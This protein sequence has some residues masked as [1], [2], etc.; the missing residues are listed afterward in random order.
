MTT[1]TYETID[2]PGSIYT[3]AEGINSKGQIVGFYQ[4]SNRIEHGF[5]YDHGVYTT[6]DPP[7]SGE[8]V[9]NGI[10]SKGQIFGFYEIGGS[11]PIVGFLY[12]QG[13]YKTI[14]P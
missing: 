7:G 14:D 1:Y 9:A 10:N 6:I 11:G 2:P 8:T 13:T 12:D 3:A 4:D 5:L